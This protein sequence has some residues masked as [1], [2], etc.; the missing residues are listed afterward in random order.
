MKITKSAVF[1]CAI[2]LV[3]GLIT[4][5]NA[6]SF[7]LTSL[8]IDADDTPGTNVE[9]N[10]L[11]DDRSP[12]GV[13]TAD[14]FPQIEQYGTGDKSINLNVDPLDTLFLATEAFGPHLFDDDSYGLFANGVEIAEFSFEDL[15][16]NLT[17]IDPNW[18]LDFVD[19]ILGDTAEFTDWVS[20]Y[21][22]A[23]KGL[24][25]N[26][27]FDAT[28]ALTYTPIPEPGTM[29]LLGTGLIGLAAAGRRR[30]KKH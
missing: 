4:S 25:P 3:F 11:N 28:Y 10:T 14:S 2:F 22:D 8:R 6:T 21:D 19:F 29:L 26:E 12:I 17:W 20:P 15:S 18:Q 13:I 16:F 5:A 27:F 30:F 23:T 1:L 9:W 24:V 7:N